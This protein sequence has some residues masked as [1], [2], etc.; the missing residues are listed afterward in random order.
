MNKKFAKHGFVGILIFLAAIAVFS[1]AAMLLWN[2]LMPPIFGLP[3]ISYLQALGLMVLVRIL[4]SG[5]PFNGIRAMRGAALWGKNNPI[6]EKWMNM[7]EEERTEFVM[8][9]RGFHNHFHGH[10]GG[11]GLAK[12][13]DAKGKEKE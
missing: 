4:L 9:E 3:A 13:N 12:G 8:R 5:L 1:I 6:R 7:T 10:A 2:W 11:E